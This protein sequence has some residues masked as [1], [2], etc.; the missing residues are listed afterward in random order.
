MDFLR[1]FLWAWGASNGAAPGTAGLIIPDK[2]ILSS[3]K[4]S[5]GKLTAVF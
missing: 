5:A 4:T 2:N 3:F 1:E